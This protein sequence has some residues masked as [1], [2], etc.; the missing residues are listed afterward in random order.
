MRDQT[1][2]NIKDVKVRATRKLNL[3]KSLSHTS[4]SSDQRT[5]LRIHQMIPNDSF[6]NPKILIR[7]MRGQVT[8]G[9]K[10]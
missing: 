10:L 6:I 8:T 4:W 3:L 9:C 7:L 2:R 5:L 1:G